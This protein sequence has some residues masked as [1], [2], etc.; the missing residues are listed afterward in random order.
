MDL[1]G[2]GQKKEHVSGS[3]LTNGSAELA[4]ALGSADG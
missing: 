2:G 1:V 4:G 3:V